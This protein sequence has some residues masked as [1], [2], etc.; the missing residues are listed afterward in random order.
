MAPTYRTSLHWHASKFAKTL[1][2][3]LLV[4]ALIGV[5]PAMA[6]PKKPLLMPLESARIDEHLTPT[7]TMGELPVTREAAQILLD[8]ASSTRLFSTTEGGDALAQTPVTIAPM[9]IRTLKK[10]TVPDAPDI[11]INMDGNA[12]VAKVGG[13]S[14]L[15]QWPFGSES[16]ITTVHAVSH[17]DYIGSNAVLS[18]LRETGEK[19]ASHP[20]TVV[21][22][23][24]KLLY[25]N[26]MMR[27]IYRME[28]GEN[29]T[30][31]RKYA[32]LTAFLPIELAQITPEPLDQFQ[33]VIE[34]VDQKVGPFK[35]RFPVL[36]L[37]PVRDGQ[38]DNSRFG[39]KV[40]VQ[41]EQ[42]GVGGF[43]GITRTETYSPL[44]LVT[45]VR[46]DG[47]AAKVPTAKP[48]SPSPVSNTTPVTETEEAV[49][50]QAGPV[51]PEVSGAIVPGSDADPLLHRAAGPNDPTTWGAAGSIGGGVGYEL[52]S[53]EVG[54]VVPASL[55]AW[56]RTYQIGFDSTLG[57]QLG[58]IV[59]RAKSPRDT[60]HYGFGLVAG[61]HLDNTVYG[62][63]V[64]VHNYKKFW[65]RKMANVMIIDALFGD[66]NG[67]LFNQNLSVRLDAGDGLF[68]LPGGFVNFGMAFPAE[69]M[70]GQF[71]A[72]VGLQLKIAI[73]GNI[74]K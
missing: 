50:D 32:Y 45:R 27:E 1:F 39:Y 15:V 42:T 7:S 14:G 66:Q 28:G 18:K 73:N 40:I 71:H 6:K 22:T 47:G 64:G 36:W 62:A 65:G 60:N 26:S 17:D 3:V 34:M 68:I 33:V 24:E 8:S 72:Q 5:T 55:S 74:P 35:N 67:L 59:L 41:L 23:N 44:G 20:V 13:T 31:Q 46:V 56:Y 30:T 29:T 2:S 69:D 61:S 70:D 49:D 4:T 52:A 51:A 37:I 19:A 10:K 53:A 58:S 54:A 12:P 16:T 63:R 43:P 57:A 9:V 48:T 11:T 38:L 21:A 25:A